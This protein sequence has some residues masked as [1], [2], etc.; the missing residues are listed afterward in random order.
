MECTNCK[1]SDEEVKLLK[2]FHKG[3]EDYVCVRCLPMFI[4]G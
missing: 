4:H 1:R 2:F 3:R